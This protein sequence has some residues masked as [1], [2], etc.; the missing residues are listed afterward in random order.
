[1]TE[2]RNAV[3]A[4]VGTASPSWSFSADQR[5]AIAELSRSEREELF[6]L[7]VMS[8]AAEDGISVAEHRVLSRLADALGFTSAELGEALDAVHR[9]QTSYAGRIQSVLG[10]TREVG[11][12]VARGVWKRARNLAQDG[13]RRFRREES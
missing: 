9:E 1:M 13:A 2:L 10:T 4:A 6:D 3:L 11:G 7:A 12:G 5:A 8:A